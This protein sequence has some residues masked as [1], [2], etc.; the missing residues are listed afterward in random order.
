MARAHEE[1]IAAMAR[2]EAKYKDQIAELQERVVE[3][4]QERQQQASSST[5]AVLVSLSTTTSGNSFALPATNKELAE[6][7]A[8]YRT[9]LA[10]YVVKAQEE[11]SK[12]VQT[13]KGKRIAKYE[14]II[15]DLRRRAKVVVGDG[16]VSN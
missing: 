8:S 5:T 15:S 1:K 6:K 16:N 2:V 7:V 10:N 4:E 11:K 3:L 13:A 9:F 12:A 14:A